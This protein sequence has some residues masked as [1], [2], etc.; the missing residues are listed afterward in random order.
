MHFGAFDYKLTTQID[1]AII[2][3]TAAIHVNKYHEMIT[4]DIFITEYWE[5]VACPT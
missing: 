1:Q 5:I 3:E 2:T 4:T